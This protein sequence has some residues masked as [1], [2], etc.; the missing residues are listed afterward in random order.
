MHF[1]SPRNRVPHRCVTAA[2]KCRPRPPSSPTPARPPDSRGAEAA[3]VNLAD[4]CT[5]AQQT[6]KHRTLGM[7]DHIADQLAHHQLGGHDEIVQF[8]KR[9]LPADVLAGLGGRP[10]ILRQLKRGDVTDGRAARMDDEECRIIRGLV[11]VRLQCGDQHVAQAVE[12]GGI[13]FRPAFGEVRR[14][15]HRSGQGVPKLGQPLVDVAR[16]RFDET[17]R[18]EHEQALLRQLHLAAVERRL[19]GAQRWIDGQIRAMDRAIGMDDKRRWMTRHRER[20]DPRHR[21]EHRVEAGGVVVIAEI[22]D[23]SIEFAEQLVGRQ[24]QV[25]VRR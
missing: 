20:A 18:A 17:V 9:E 11:P 21:I 10:G 13:A 12:P 23:Q 14:P 2:T 19:G 24:V 6:Q 3:V 16:G 7:S 25:G 15:A 1:P 5:V 8:P 4:Q 22:T